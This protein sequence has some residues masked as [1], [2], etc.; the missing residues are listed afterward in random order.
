MR[1]LWLIALGCGDESGFEEPVVD[2]QLAGL[3]DGWAEEV[4]DRVMLQQAEK[5]D[6]LWVV[7][8]TRNMAPKL[9][10]VNANID[11]YQRYLETSGLD[12]RMA[13]M[14]ADA[15]DA[16]SRGRL[17]EDDDVRWVEPT[18][19]MGRNVFRRMLNQV[20]A[21]GLYGDESFRAFERMVEREED[22]AEGFLRDDASLQVVVVSPLDERS[23]QEPSTESFLRDLLALKEP[24]LTVNWSGVV[25]P[26]EG[27]SFRGP[28]G[29]VHL[30]G[31]QRHLFMAENT[32]GV[33]GSFC[34]DDWVPILDELGA[35]T[36]G[37]RVE[38]YLSAVPEPD[39]LEVW[40]EFGSEEEEGRFVY[41]GQ[42]VRHVDDGRFDRCD[43]GHC[44][45]F[46]YLSQRNSIQLLDYTPPPGAEVHMKYS[47]RAEK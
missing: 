41:E 36:V 43:E 28:D 45:T 18:T 21:L 7:D 33:T 19:P 16:V 1:W 37:Y 35:R 14:R 40:A 38:L 6:V 3:P 46:A 29:D 25:P 9:D 15:A 4:H 5:L 23:G 27:C 39:T 26:A 11:V 10:V 12:W 17:I 13:L 30:F 22:R 47:V 24:G 44:F 20:G 8:D 34:E 42:D 32:E 2:E 31:A